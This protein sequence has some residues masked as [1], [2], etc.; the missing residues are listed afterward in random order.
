MSFVTKIFDFIND[1]RGAESVEFGIVTVTIAG[2]A[3]A[4]LTLTKNTLQTK[5]DLMLT[6][7]N[8]DPS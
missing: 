1:E 6:T 3:A 4:G 2:G 7:I 8:V 5:N